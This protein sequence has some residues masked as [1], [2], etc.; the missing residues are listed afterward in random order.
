[1]MFFY[2][3]N[4]IEKITKELNKPIVYPKPNNLTLFNPDNMPDKNNGG[5]KRKN[6]RSKKYSLRKNK[7]RKNKTRKKRKTIKR[8][9]TI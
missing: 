6:K 1:M 8:L 7:L 3:P 2:R 9:K 4:E 5:N